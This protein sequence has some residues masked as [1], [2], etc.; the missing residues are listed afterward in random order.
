MAGVAGTNYAALWDITDNI[1]DTAGEQNKAMYADG[2]YQRDLYNMIKSIVEAFDGITAKLDADGGVTDEDYVTNCAL[3]AMGASG[4]LIEPNGI[5]N[6][7]L[8]T[9]L[10]EMETKFEVLTAQLDADGGVEDTDYGDLDFDIDTVNITD[11][12]IHD[13]GVVI[14]YLQEVVAAIAAL[15]AQLDADES[16]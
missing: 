7:K 16:E 10:E 13:Q 1:A 6:V 2:V 9:A 8:V 14:N 4:N 15:N 5:D 12:G 11:E 3:T